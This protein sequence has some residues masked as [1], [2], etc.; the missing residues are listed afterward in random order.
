MTRELILASGSPR[1]AALLR[2]AGYPI[3][4]I[5]PD[6]EELV[7]P[8]EAPPDYVQRTAREKARAV[9]AR[10]DA[11]G[12]PILAADTVV[13]IDREILEK[14]RDEADAAG[15]LRRLAGRE[16]Q[17][18]TGVCILAA[19]EC[20]FVESTTVRFRAVDPGD[21]DRYVATGEPMDKAGA[22][23]IQGGAG[24]MVAGLSGSYSNVVGLPMERVAA[25]L[26]SL[27]Y[28]PTVMR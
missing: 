21:I 26:E 24:P 8:G 14:P 15:M 13:V 10:E 28:R 18:M 25:E 5:P 19:A 22:Y 11:R 7:R 1:R 27:G 3:R 17:V 23:A 2:E 9:A 16:H 4:V 6:V 12:R 20:L